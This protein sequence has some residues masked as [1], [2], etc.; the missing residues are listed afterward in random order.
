MADLNGDLL[1]LV[2]SNGLDATILADVLHRLRQDAQ[3]I[4]SG[5]KRLRLQEAYSKVSQRAASL[6]G[7]VHA[8]LS[9]WAG[10]DG[11]HRLSVHLLTKLQRALL[12]G[13]V[14]VLGRK[15]RR[16]DEPA[17]S[18]WCTV[19]TDA[20][21]QAVYADL[22]TA[23][24]CVYIAP[25]GV[26]VATRG[27][28]VK[29]QGLSGL[30]KT[31]KD[32][33]TLVESLEPHKPLR[34]VSFAGDAPPAVN[35]YNS[36]VAGACAY[37]D[38]L[39]PSIGHVK[40]ASANAIY[41]YFEE[42][43]NGHHLGQAERLIAQMLTDVG[44]GLTPLVSAGSKKDA[45]LAYKN[46]LMRRAFVHESMAK[47]VK[48]AQADG[49]IELTVVRGDVAGTKFESYGSLVFELYYR[50]DLASLMG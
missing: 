30:P 35:G 44:K 16:P 37:A 20:D 22:L 3:K 43:R 49:Q 11:G 45:A 19:W 4:N 39:P 36:F 2:L 50:V 24:P 25:D 33:I 14:E 42:R 1:L 32:L 6:M 13:G 34:S 46:G 15:H 40:S 28:R 38:Q 41:Q 5:K 7:D 26:F 9:C 18:A 23:E 12:T 21:A 48:R 31:V 17:G 47:F 29:C 8:M 10:P 27:K